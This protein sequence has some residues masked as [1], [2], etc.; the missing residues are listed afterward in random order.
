M[1]HKA[2]CQ[3]G[4]LSVECTG[5]PDFV[6]VCNCTQCQRRSGSA[7]ALAAF[8]RR[9]RTAVEGTQKTW[10]RTGGSGH[11]LT[12]HFCPDC[13][14]SVFW[15]NGLRPEHYG[16]AIGCLTTPPPEPEAVIFLSEKQPWLSFPEGWRQCQRSI[17]E[18]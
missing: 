2:L 17:A 5:D 6:V 4:Q 14:T 3:C 10:A 16:I 18:G 11:L 13:G 12:N 8:F 15:E 1:Q 7:F 9:D